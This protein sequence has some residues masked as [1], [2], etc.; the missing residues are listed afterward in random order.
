MTREERHILSRK[1]RR[2]LRLAYL[3]G[4]LGTAILWFTT[5]KYLFPLFTPIDDKNLSMG[6]ELLIMLGVVLGFLAPLLTGLILGM[7]SQMT[8]NKIKEE[9]KGLF[10]NKNINYVRI[11]WEMLQ[12]R[13]YDL[14]KAMYNNFIGGNYRYFCNGM[15]TGFVYLDGSPED[16]K[17]AL[18][19]MSDYIKPE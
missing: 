19:R 7:Y 11:F 13:E 12:R 5:I 16:Y 1:Y 17:Q 14:A 8:I 4:L 6:M 3:I 10:E 9:R 2:Q 18:E 15:F